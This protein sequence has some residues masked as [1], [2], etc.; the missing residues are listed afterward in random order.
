MNVQDFPGVVDGGGSQ[1]LIAA[2]TAA[3]AKRRTDI[4]ES[5][6]AGLFGLAAPDDLARYQPDE[7]AAIAEQSWSTLAQRAPGTPKIGFEPAPGVRGV[8]VLDVVNDDM[9]FLLDSVLGELNQRGLEA[10]LLVH[11]VFSVERDA[12]GVLTAFNGAAKDQGQR[13]SFI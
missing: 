6:V 9:P 1:A 4:P 8:A 3:L 13:E 2:A 7:L 12:T 11:P 5:F 10:R